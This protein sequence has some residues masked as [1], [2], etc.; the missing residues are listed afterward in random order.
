MQAHQLSLQQAE[1][2]DQREEL[3]ATRKQHVLAAYL[4]GLYKTMEHMRLDS[5]DAK[6]D[7]QLA[8]ME[9]E[10]VMR[11]VRPIALAYLDELTLT[12]FDLIRLANNN[13]ET[14]I[15]E[16]RKDAD[17]KWRLL[18]SLTDRAR[19]LAQATIDSSKPI[20]V[21]KESKQIANSHYRCIALLRMEISIS[22]PL[23]DGPHR[24]EFE[25]SVKRME[26]SLVKGKKLQERLDAEEDLSF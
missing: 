5:E 15:V 11:T 17:Q 13:L 7:H 9:V 19:E 26:G 16:A 2:K 18:R 12:P 25:K 22:T 3:V 23:V 8:V 1:L 10:N 6:T 14:A 21:G 4:S 20:A 24:T